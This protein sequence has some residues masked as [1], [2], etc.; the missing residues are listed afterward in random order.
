MMIS[1]SL[2]YVRCVVSTRGLPAI[3]RNAQWVKLSHFALSMAKF[4][5]R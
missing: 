4:L 2:V 3:T 5:V 1:A